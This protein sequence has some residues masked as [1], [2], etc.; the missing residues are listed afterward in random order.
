MMYAESGSRVHAGS[1]F[2]GSDFAGSDFAGSDC[3]MFRQSM[4]TKLQ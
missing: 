1:D 2:A 3:D 4:L